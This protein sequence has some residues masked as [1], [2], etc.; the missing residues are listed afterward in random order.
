M[1]EEAINITHSE[2][3][4]AAFNIQHAMRM[5]G[6]ILS[7][8]VCPFLPYILYYIR[9]V[10]IS[11]KKI[12]E[13]KMCA[14]IFSTDSFCNISHSKNNAERYDQKYVLVFM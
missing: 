3:V 10:T 8:V 2:C 5:R 1:F 7:S 11:E 14:L 6:A 13:H 4:F 9:R 12:I